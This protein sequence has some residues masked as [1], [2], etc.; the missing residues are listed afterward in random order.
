MPGAELPAPSETPVD[1]AKDIRPL[2]EQRCYG[3]HGTAQQINGLR[4]DRRA[5]ALKGGHSGPAIVPGDSAGSRL[6]HLVAGYRVKV[7]MP[8]GGP[9][10]SPEEIGKLRAWIDGGAVWPEAPRVETSERAEHWAYRPPIVVD[11]PSDAH[12]IDGFVRTRLEVERVDAAPEAD[13][14]TL[15]RRVSLDLTGLPPPPRQVDRFLEAGY[16]AFVDELLDSDHYGEKWAMHWLDQV[17]YADSDGYEKDNVRP[18]AW[19]Y[20]HWVINAL[21]RDMPF[22]RFTI[23]QIA[24]DLLE[25][26]TTEQLVATGFH[27][28][29]LRNREGGVNFEQFRFEETVDRA[30]TVATVWLGMTYGCAQCHD[31]KYDPISQREFYS[32]YAFFNSIEEGFVHAPLAGEM[33]PYL[34]THREYRAHRDELLAEHNVPELQAP[35]EQ[36]VKWHGVNPGRHTAWDVNWDTLAKMSDGGERFV[37]IPAGERTER[38]RDVVT[39]Y[40]LRF[41]SQVVSSDRYKELGFAQ[42]RKT[43]AQLKESYPQ[44]SEA[45]VV[46]ERAP[47]RPTHIQVRGQW[48]R[49][50][51]PVTAAV[52]AALPAMGRESPT[53]LDLAR[54]LVSGENPLTA[55]VIVNRIWHEYFG[56]GLVAT[57]DD[58]GVR[59]DQ[60]SHPELL[61]WLADDF[62][63][64]GWSLKH[65]HRRIV[66]SAT[67]RQS[68]DARPDLERRDPDNRLLARQRR[69]RLPA[70]LIRDGA[71]AA[72]GLLS[73][74]VGGRSVKPLQPD[75]VSKLAY[76]SETPWVTSTGGEAYRRGLY[77]HFQ[78]M[79][80]YPF[81]MTFDGT[82]RQ[83]AECTREQ[84]NTPLQAL[85]L[86]NDPV[87][88]EASQGLA[89][90]V[91][92]ETPSGEFNQRL[93]YAYRLALGREPS[94]SERERVARYYQG[95]MRLLDNSPE[96]AREWFPA[97]LEG[98]DQSVAAAWTG[99]GR[100]LLNLDEFITRE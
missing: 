73:D 38:Q 86:L 4:L 71:L 34:R 61:D 14:R 74:Q 80:P 96:A 40:F 89:A 8:P 35:W 43:L 11:P 26:P 67:Y 91:L 42:L 20:R 75:S 52:P 36:K 12:P 53:R 19:R 15:L 64:S 21:N 58:F 49:Q 95:Q 44:L 76:R 2:F 29:T 66:T 77:I 100:L 63:R 25:D 90:R 68:S 57:T 1:F 98:Q 97:T 81:L 82:E 3:C 48:D 92:L 22:D 24:G 78:R 7:V 55:R 16:E 99:V 10:L 5:D 9:E 72:S 33:G 17:R 46:T 39:D 79:S 45:R 93:K 59:G 56:R 51:V 6:I 23:E 37:H 62:V 28:N 65:L 27:R 47:R 60:P 85:N 30:S 69:L 50:G 41:Y 87:F 88:M 31:H 70:E 18:H 32:F 83:V 13:P 94:D 84:S 54:W